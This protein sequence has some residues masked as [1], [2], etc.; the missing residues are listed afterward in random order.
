MMAS[1]QNVQLSAAVVAT[2]VA[3]AIPM[4]NDK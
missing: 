2:P 1:L 4:S 3:H